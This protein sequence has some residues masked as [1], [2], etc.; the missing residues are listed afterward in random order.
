V[1]DEYYDLG[2]GIKVKGDQGEGFFVF[3]LRNM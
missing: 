3:F 2:F 1:P